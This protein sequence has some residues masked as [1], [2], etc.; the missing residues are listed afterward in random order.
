MN[1]GPAPTALAGGIYSETQRAEIEG[2]LFKDAAGV[3]PPVDV[4]QQAILWNSCHVL[5]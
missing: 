1:K 2:A 4:D 3:D 5:A